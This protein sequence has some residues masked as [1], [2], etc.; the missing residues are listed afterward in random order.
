MPLEGLIKFCQNVGNI[1]N[2]EVNATDSLYI[3][4]INSSL[5]F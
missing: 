3:P 2:Y 5:I 4:T 1:W